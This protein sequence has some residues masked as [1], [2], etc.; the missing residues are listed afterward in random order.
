MKTHRSTIMVSEKTAIHIEYML[1]HVPFSAKDCMGEDETLTFTAGFQDRMSVDVKVCGVK[2]REGEDN[3]PWTEAVLFRNN[4]EVCCTEPRETVFGEWVLEDDDDEYIVNVY[5][6]DTFA[7]DVIRARSEGTLDAML[8]SGTIIPFQFTDNGEENAFVVGRDS[9]N[10]YMVLQ[11]CMET[12]FR[13]DQEPGN[14]GGWNGSAMKEHVQELFGLLPDTFR[15]LALP[16]RIRQRCQETV[17]ESID[18]AF[19]L[20]ASQVFGYNSLKEADCGDEQIDI[21]KSRPARI[22]HCAGETIASSWY[23]RSVFN[24]TEYFHVDR[25]GIYDTT[26]AN[27]N[28][29]VV[30]AIC[31]E[32]KTNGPGCNVALR[33]KPHDEGLTLPEVTELYQMLPDGTEAVPVEFQGEYSTAMGFI[34]IETADRMDYIYTELNEYVKEILDDMDM[35]SPDGRYMFAHGGETVSLLIRR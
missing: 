1:K 28:R 4:C 13:M 21:F 31:I 20:S 27:R 19:L 15:E 25:E 14:R 34:D 16:A 22:K 9:Q 6:E 7:Q 3:Q 11:D 35:E 23:L 33:E 24:K 8:P 32:Q 18:T 10:T 12:R 2:Y 30:F 26:A 5:R 29:G 17:I